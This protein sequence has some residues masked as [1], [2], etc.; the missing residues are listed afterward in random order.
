M[1]T[2]P[3]AGDFV[4]D[5]ATPDYWNGWLANAIASAVTNLRRVDQEAAVE[6]Y[7]KGD[8]ARSLLSSLNAFLEH[9]SNADSIL[10]AVGDTVLWGW[11][12]EDARG[13]PYALRERYGDAVRAARDAEGYLDGAATC[14]HPAAG[15]WV[16]ERLP[17]KLRQVT[18]AERRDLLD[19]W[20][21][22]VLDRE[23]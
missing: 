12:V 1:T 15:P 5:D 4:P 9:P 11:L 14:G 8:V 10:Q 6:V 3:T 19:E 7:T 23:P 20:G 16:R 13:E 18:V 21:T 17:F 2:T 22:P